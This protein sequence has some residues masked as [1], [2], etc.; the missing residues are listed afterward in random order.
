M[1]IS[2]CE[3]YFIGV[4]GSISTVVD[5]LLSASLVLLAT[6]LAIYFFDFSEVILEE[7]K[8]PAFW[9]FM[10]RLSLAALLFLVLA[11]FLP[12]KREMYLMIGVPAIEHSVLFQKAPGLALQAAEQ[13][14]QHLK[15]ENAAQAHK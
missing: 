9:K 7:D 14:V 15:E 11:I 12:G 5:V 3:I 6:G 1:L 4:V 10:K 2:A 13:Y 8:H